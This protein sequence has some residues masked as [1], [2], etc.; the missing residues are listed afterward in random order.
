MNPDA[1]VTYQ[2]FNLFS[3]EKCF[4]YFISDARH[5]IRHSTICTIL[6]KVDVLDTC[7]A[8]AF[9]LF[10]MKIENAVYTSFENSTLLFINE[11][12]FDIMNIQ[13]NQSLEF[14]WI[15]MLARIRFVNDWRFFMAY[16]NSLKSF[17]DWLNSVQH[18]QGN[19]IKD[20][21]QKI[22][23]NI[24]SIENQR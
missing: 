11:L 4:I 16:N 13:N 24:W 7:G 6:V 18:C 5:Y 8:I 19:F 15:P 22:V 20:I 14:E 2:T 1:D 9:L 10:F 23:A 17:Q 3:S 21:G 12:I